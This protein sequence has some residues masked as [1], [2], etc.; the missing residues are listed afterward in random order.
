MSNAA[1]LITPEMKDDLQIYK[2]NNIITS[3]KKRRLFKPPNN[4][5][6]DLR[7]PNSDSST[8]QSGFAAGQGSNQSFFLNGGEDIGPTLSPKGTPSHTPV[9][10]HHGI[11]KEAEDVVPQRNIR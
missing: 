7:S 9:A 3:Y 11:P 2:S 5:R 10:M 1:S 8:Y 6:L 4:R